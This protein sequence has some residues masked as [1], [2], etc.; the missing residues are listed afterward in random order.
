LATGLELDAQN[1]V[2]LRVWSA[3]SI[4]EEDGY[5]TVLKLF[6]RSEPPDAVYCTGDW[7]AL[8]AV[9]ALKERGLRIPRDVSIVGGTGLDLANASCPNL[10]RTQ[11]PF[12]KIGAALLNLLCERIEQN[13]KD[14]PGRILPVGFVGGATTRPPENAQLGIAKQ[15][16]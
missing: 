5:Q 15:Q 7:L 6:G 11:Q 9:R 16:T 4:R 8:G 14:L 12:E 2:A 13:G 3:Q 1:D 10:T